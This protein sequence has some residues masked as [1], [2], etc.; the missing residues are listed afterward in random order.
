MPVEHILSAL[1]ELNHQCVACE[2][3]RNCRPNTA[4]GALCKQFHRL[5]DRAI[6][7]TWRDAAGIVRIYASGP[8]AWTVH[9]TPFVI[10]GSFQERANR[11]ERQYAQFPP[12]D[13]GAKR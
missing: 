6:A 11:A 5:V 3:E 1:E 9:G 13:K 7:E 12:F 8:H 2:G 10:E 4:D